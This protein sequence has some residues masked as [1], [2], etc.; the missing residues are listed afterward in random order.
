MLIDR[1]K[2]SVM[3]IS[4]FVNESNKF[5]EYKDF[6]IETDSSKLRQ[7]TLTSIGRG[8]MPLPPFKIYIRLLIITKIYVIIFLVKRGDI[9]CK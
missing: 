7:D 3:D 9:I 8:G 6:R 4:R 1:S 2:M 5:R